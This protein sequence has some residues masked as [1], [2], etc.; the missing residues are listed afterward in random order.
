MKTKAVKIGIPDHIMVGRVRIPLAEINERE[1]AY[2]GWLNMADTK[3]KRWGNVNVAI[4]PKTLRYTAWLDYPKIGQYDKTMM[5]TFSGKLTG[6]KQ[7]EMNAKIGK[8][9]LML[10]PYKETLREIA[11]SQKPRRS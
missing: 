4:D 3:T 6:I 11:A 2:Q 7:R 5:H 8:Y 10:Y 9:I 1:I